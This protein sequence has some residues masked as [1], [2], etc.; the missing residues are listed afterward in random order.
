MSPDAVI[1]FRGRLSIFS[2][3]EEEYFRKY[4]ETMQSIQPGEKEGSALSPSVLLEEL[5]ESIDKLDD[6]STEITHEVS[7]SSVLGGLGDL[8]RT[9]MLEIIDVYKEKQVDLEPKQIKD[10]KTNHQDLLDCLALKRGC[11]DVLRNCAESKNYGIGVLSINWC[12]ILIE[13]LLVQPLCD[14]SSDASSEVPI[15]SNSVDGEGIVSLPFPGAISKKEQIR[16]LQ[17]SSED[18][19]SRVVY[20]GDSSTDL[21]AILQADVGILL[22]GSQSAASLAKRYGFFVKPLS[23]CEGGDSHQSVV[24]TADSWDEIGSF[25]NRIDW[26]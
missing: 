26:E 16:K 24:W 11:L 14:N 17:K 10:I 19:S 13:S 1:D 22:G 2:K 8:S 21:L 12:P 4:T 15:W 6:V 7:K 3:L 9:E 20:V 23:E 5:S 18:G 25:L